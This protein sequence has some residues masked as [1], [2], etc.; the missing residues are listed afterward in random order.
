M[1]K[2]ST[3]DLSVCKSQVSALEQLIE[4]YEKAVLEQADKL[5]GEIDERKNAE[6]HLLRL[7]RT[8]RMLSECNGTLVHA[9]EE[10]G[11]VDGICRKIVELGGY[12]LAWVDYTG[13]ESRLHEEDYPLSREAHRRDYSA[14]AFPLMANTVRLGALC[15]CTRA[16]E[17]AFDDEET[18]ILVELADDLAF[19]IQSL[20]T[21]V[22]RNRA[23]DTL[24]QRQRAIE[25]CSNGIIITDATLHD[26]PIIYVN[27][28]F[29]GI[30]GYSAREVIGK[31]P[32]FLLGNDRD[33]LGSE[34]IRAALREQ[35]ETQAVLSNYRKDGSLFWNDL[36]IAPVRDESGRV[37]NFVGVQ[38]DITELKRYEQDL[39]RQ[40]NYD[41]LTGLANRNLFLE[42]LAHEIAHSQ[43]NRKPVAVAFL[44]LDHFKIVNDSLGHSVGDELLKII[45]GR[46]RSCIRT[47]DTAARFGGDEFALLFPDQSCADNVMSIVKRISGAVSC[48]SLAGELKKV[49]AAVSE[50]I[51]LAETDI[52]VTCSIGVSIYPQDG[53]DAEA[54]LKN[55]D[56]ALYRV[57][58][59][60]RNAFQFYTDELNKK[61]VARMQMEKHLRRALENGEFFLHYQPQV[62]LDEG[63]VTGME[64]L[65][66]WRNPELGAVPPL[67]FIPLAEEI[68]LIVPIG[69]WALK[70]ACAQGKAWQD[71]GLPPK[72]IAVNISARQF[73]R[74]DLLGMVSR[75]LQ[76]TGLD[77]VYLELEIVERMVIQDV[78]SAAVMLKKFK[79]LEVQLSMDDFGT[80]YSSLSYLQSLPFDK[81]KIDISFVRGVANDNNSMAIV[82]AIIG[83]AHNLNLRVIAEGVETQEQLARLQELG[84][85]EIQGF[86]FSRPVPAL[87]LEKILREDRRLVYPSRRAV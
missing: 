61:I 71:A 2:S 44:D 72:T 68:G 33:Q 77:P 39:E 83:M 84:C 69:E 37:T 50:P 23:E 11:L 76:E 70:L 45:A 30:T 41:V 35:A 12:A 46:L 85:D 40:A 10:P 9:V 54:L 31:N 1:N 74:Q 80:G 25:S 63:R 14:A 73:W 66:R 49:L 28:A 6:Q 24:R 53:A 34:R 78:E 64:A 82:K 52:N 79:K 38:N 7:N 29:E 67:K 55:A 5:L 17:D 15:L 57:K 19:G 81:I 8:L 27:A 4:V 59:Q 36:K 58:E 26:N 43:R 47:S 87:D 42:R 48:F 86:Y 20:R 65:L 56:M 51:S 13:E 21:G 62:S 75:V 32:R 18:K 60:G 3:D 22:Q 16:R